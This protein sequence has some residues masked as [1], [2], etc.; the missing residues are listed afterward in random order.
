[1]WTLSGVT[2]E[3]EEGTATV[4]STDPLLVA[5]YCPIT[6]SRT[7][8]GCSSNNMQCLLPGCARTSLECVH[9]HEAAIV[10]AG[11]GVP[12]LETML[13]EEQWEELLGEAVAAAAAHKSKNTA[14]S[15]KPVPFH[16][17]DTYMTARALE[18]ACV[19]C[20][21]FFLFIPKLPIDVQVHHQCPRVNPAWAVVRGA[22]IVCRACRSRRAY[23]A[24]RGM[25]V[26]PC[27]LAGCVP[28][29]PPCWGRTAHGR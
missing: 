17:Q 3:G 7:V 10:V 15:S 6:K 16:P 29:W 1:M 19:C 24:R 21:S 20:R 2:D 26:T 11:S 13:P 8:V 27:A 9:V 25:Q 22:G 4:I 28:P 12:E 14:V 18:G 5:V 23:V